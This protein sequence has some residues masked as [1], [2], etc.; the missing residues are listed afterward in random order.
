MEIENEVD[1]VLSSICDQESQKMETFRLLHDEK[2]SKA[3]ISLEKKITGYS[4]MTRMNKPNPEY[5]D[6]KEG[7][8]RDEK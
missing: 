6:P 7:G 2:A 3:M 5:K 8:S 4:N 1:E